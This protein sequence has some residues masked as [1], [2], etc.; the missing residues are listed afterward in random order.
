MYEFNCG[1]CHQLYEPTSVPKNR[2]K[3]ILSKMQPKAKITDQETASI[4]NY[5]ISN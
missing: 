1:R 3:T 4:Y 5:L 2:W